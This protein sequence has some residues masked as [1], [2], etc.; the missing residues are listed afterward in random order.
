MVQGIGL[1]N[2]IRHREVSLRSFRLF[3]LSALLSVAVGCGGG[4]GDN[5]GTNTASA[6]AGFIVAAR[7]NP[8]EINIYRVDQPNAPIQT[9]PNVFFTSGSNILDNAGKRVGVYWSGPLG[10][11][12]PTALGIFT[13]SQAVTLGAEAGHE[14]EYIGYIGSLAPRVLYRDIAAPSNVSLRSAKLDGTDSRELVGGCLTLD[15]PVWS[16]SGVAVRC[17]KGSG[18]GIWFSDGVAPA[19]QLPGAASR[20]PKV[21]TATNLVLYDPSGTPSL[22]TQAIA[23]PFTQQKLLL[24]NLGSDSPEVHVSPAGVAWVRTFNVLD[25]QA[26]QAWVVDT[27]NPALVQSRYKSSGVPLFETMSP[28]G[29]RFA[30]IYQNMNGA[31]LGDR[32]WVMTLDATAPDIGVEVTPPSAPLTV[33]DISI[34]ESGKILVTRG[35]SLNPT[36]IYLHDANGSNVLQKGDVGLRVLGLRGEYAFLGDA[37]SSGVLQSVNLAVGGGLCT[38]EIAAAAPVPSF[39]SPPGATPQY[40]TYVNDANQ[41]WI[42]DPDLCIAQRIDLTGTNL[43]TKIGE[44][45]G[46]RVFLV[47]NREEGATDQDDIVMVDLDTLVTT[48]IV[49]GPTSDYGLYFPN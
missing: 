14:Y 43:V 23:A 39:V 3:A 11:T 5:T 28:D 44:G 19:V 33:S 16:A 30:G 17:D 36:G 20:Q 22:F 46:N 25:T 45:V 49:S 37:N 31:G 6:N 47:L 9:I 42:A 27:A 8:R 13:S 32:S 15:L 10:V 24:G 38:L 2:G 12:Y 34:L 18:N 4:G 29:L 35:T 7:V 48:P 40:V 1:P 21:L 26:W 41:A